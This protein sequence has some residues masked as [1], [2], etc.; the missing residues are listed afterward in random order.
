MPFFDT[1]KAPHDKFFRLELGHRGKICAFYAEGCRLWTA[2]KPPPPHH[3]PH[4]NILQGEKS[5]REWSTENGDNVK[6]WKADLAAPG[7][8]HNINAML[9]VSGRLWCGAQR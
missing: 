3:P 2:G 9:L 6:T 4:K 8:A 7:V 1:E 5:I